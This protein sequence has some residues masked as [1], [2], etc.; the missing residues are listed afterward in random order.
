MEAVRVTIFLSFALAGT[1][2]FALSAWKLMELFTMR[3]SAGQRFYP[4]R[5][6]AL[7]PEVH[8]DANAPSPESREDRDEF[9]RV[10]R[11]L[12]SFTALAGLSWLLGTAF[13]QITGM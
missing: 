9:I 10:R 7:H 13:F 8:A 11:R 2:F 3:M 4:R 5:P 1:V 12:F 6:F